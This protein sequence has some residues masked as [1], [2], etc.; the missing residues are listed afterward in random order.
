[1]LGSRTFGALSGFLTLGGLVKAPNPL[2]S[3]C[4]FIVRS[5]GNLYTSGNGITARIR[6]KWLITR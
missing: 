1:M 6:L 2:C 4:I 5:A 3:S